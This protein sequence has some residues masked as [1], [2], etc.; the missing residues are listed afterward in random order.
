MYILARLYPISS[1]TDF[2]LSPSWKQRLSTSSFSST[3][4]FLGCS[5]VF[6]M[7][8]DFLFAFPFLH[9]ESS[10]TIFLD[11]DI[12]NVW[13]FRLPNL[14]DDT[15]SRLWLVVSVNTFVDSFQS[16]ICVQVFVRTP[17]QRVQALTL[18][19]RMMSISSFHMLTPLIF[20]VKATSAATGIYFVN[21]P[22]VE[23]FTGITYEQ[24]S[25]FP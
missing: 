4:G 11:L 12:P 25:D 22:F 10:R 13:R 21:L 14:F 1:D 6:V 24:I 17:V 7:D 16:P 15:F 9:L 8:S 5:A 3:D 2:M 23:F 18:S 20:I 19:H